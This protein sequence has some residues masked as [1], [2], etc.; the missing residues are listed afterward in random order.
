VRRDLGDRLARGSGTGEWWRRRRAPHQGF[1]GRLSSREWVGVGRRS[2]NVGW[3]SREGHEARP[4]RFC[5]GSDTTSSAERG[6]ESKGGWM[7]T[8]EVERKAEREWTD[9]HGVVGVTASWARTREI[10]TRIQSKIEVRTH[11][12]VTDIAQS[13]TNKY[14]T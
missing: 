14:E 9:G 8:R 4:R 5:S 7:D 3:R 1:Q 10:L 2:C 11:R 12:Q 6:V 13:V